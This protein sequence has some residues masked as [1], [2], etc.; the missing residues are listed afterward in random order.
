MLINLE[1]F[2]KKSIH[3]LLRDFDT[4]RPRSLTEAI[5]ASLTPSQRSILNSWIIYQ[6][7]LLDSST[8]SHIHPKRMDQLKLSL[9][10]L[11]VFESTVLPVV[12][13]LS[14]K[15]VSLSSQLPRNCLGSKL[16]SDTGQ[17]STTLLCRLCIGVLHQFHKS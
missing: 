14:V 7:L 8:A 3:Q 17:F 15:R 10:F 12:S 11:S 1:S 9:R 13:L 5:L 6:S 4:T 2:T 16:L